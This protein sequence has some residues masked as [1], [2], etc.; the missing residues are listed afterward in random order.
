MNIASLMARSFDS[1]MYPPYTCSGFTEAQEEQLAELF[2]QW[3][4]NEQDAGYNFWSFRMCGD[5]MV[6]VDRDT[7]RN[8]YCVDSFEKLLADLGERFSGNSINMRYRALTANDD[9]EKEV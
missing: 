6:V 7:W 8:P 4:P 3:N 2:F 1:N 9:K 5:G